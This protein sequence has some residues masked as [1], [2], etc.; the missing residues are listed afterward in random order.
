[1]QREIRGRRAPWRLLLLAVVACAS[2][3]L[4]ARP[5]QGPAQGQARGGG[6]ATPQSGQASDEDNKNVPDGVTADQ[7]GF[8][9]LFDGRTMTG[10]NL[11]ARSGHSSTSGNK[12]PGRWE[13]RVRLANVSAMKFW[14]RA[15]SAWTDQPATSHPFSIEGVN[16]QV[17][18]VDSSKK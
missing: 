9:S 16:W 18:R 1:M 15:V 7:A 14:S 4:Q 10:W 6:Q 5:D 12:S 8:V 3:M 2:V 11:N 17:F 13:I